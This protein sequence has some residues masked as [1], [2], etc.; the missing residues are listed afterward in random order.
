MR[1]LMRSV[2]S[3]SAESNQ[4]LFFMGEPRLSDIAPDLVFKRPRDVSTRRSSSLKTGKK[5]EE[6]LQHND[7]MYFPIPA[8]EDQ[9]PVEACGD[10]EVFLTED[11]AR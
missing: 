10:E 1:A 3:N 6:Q 8:S 7:L 5:L 4:E 11:S 9:V 2:S